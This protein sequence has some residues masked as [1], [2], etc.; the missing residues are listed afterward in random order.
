[1]LLSCADSSGGRPPFPAD[2]GTAVRHDHRGLSVR[3]SGA[4]T[5][6]NPGAGPPPPG[7]ASEVAKSLSRVYPG[8]IPLIPPSG[9]FLESLERRIAVSEELERTIDRLL[10]ECGHAPEE[11]EKIEINGAAGTGMEDMECRAES[12]R[13]FEGQIAFCGRSDVLSAGRIGN[14][15][16]SEPFR[17]SCQIRKQRMKMKPNI[18]VCGKTGVGKTSLIQAVT[19]RGVVPDAR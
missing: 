13:Q 4:E 7:V 17:N 11:A 1:M 18:L 5:P 8:R 12:E 19:H 16:G 15:F 6:K 3:K 10:E 2:F 14:S 9:G